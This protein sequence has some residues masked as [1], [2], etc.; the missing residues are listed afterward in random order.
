MSSDSNR[1]YWVSRARRLV[2]RVNFAWWLSRF[3]PLAFVLSL[4]SLLPLLLL[5]GA[6][7]ATLPFWIVFFSLHGTCV[8]ATAWQVRA[9]GENTD[10]ALARLD[11]A[12]SLHTR[13]SAAF[14]GVGQWPPASVEREAANPLCWKLGR[15]GALLLAALALPALA[16]L[17]PIGVQAGSPLVA[18]APPSLED[19]RTWARELRE[20]KIVEPEALATLEKKAKDLLCGAR[21]EWYKAG[22]LEAAGRLREQTAQTLRNL[23]KDLASIENAIAQATALMEQIPEPLADTL[24]KSITEALQG[25]DLS[26]LP[27]NARQRDSL[28]GLDIKALMK[29]TPEQMAALAQAIKNSRAAIARN[30]AMKA[31]EKIASKPPESGIPVFIFAPGEKPPQERLLTLAGAGHEALVASAVTELTIADKE[32]LQKA[33]CEKGVIVQAEEGV[34]EG[35]APGLV[36]MPRPDSTGPPD[37]AM[38]AALSTMLASL[39]SPAIPSVPTAQERACLVQAIRDGRV[40]SCQFSI[41]K[42]QKDCQNLSSGANNSTCVSLNLAICARG[43]RG[44]GPS[45]PLTLGNPSETIVAKDPKMLSHE[46]LEHASLGDAQGIGIGKH[47]VNQDDYSGTVN[48]G[49]LSSAGEG[50]ESVWVDNLTPEENNTLRAYFK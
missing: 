24:Q 41:K 16:A 3:A 6:E 39:L 19:V 49:S 8:L 43:G 12:L 27:L 47:K 36:L 21:E 10:S 40:R 23:D 14:A 11:N 35:E 25:L 26:D 31:S 5:R 34:G 44:G 4:V 45:A 38:E 37:A 9:S 29:M 46:N 48:A 13:L 50:G 1:D 28:R 2:W 22:I 18:Q 30:G 20:E 32:F 7:V 42:N 33:A 17:A 15:T